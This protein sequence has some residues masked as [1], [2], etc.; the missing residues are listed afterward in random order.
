MAAR[1]PAAAANRLKSSLFSS[2]QGKALAKSKASLLFGNQLSCQ[3]TFRRAVSPVSSLQYPKVAYTLKEACKLVLQKGDI[4]TWYIDGRHDA[5][6][7][8]ANERMLGGGGV[9][10]AIHRAAGP[11]LLKACEDIPEVRPGVRCPTGSARI[12]RG[13]NLPVSKVIHTVGPIYESPK[14]SSALLASAYKSCIDIAKDH[15]IKYIAFPAISCGVY[16]YPLR[17]AS[18]VA[19]QTLGSQA[20]SIEEV[21]FVLFGEDAWKAWLSTA[22]RLSKKGACC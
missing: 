9:D 22:D 3:V 8:A 2:S 7:N 4:T 15:G 19:L 21:H 11:E 14:E 17:E 10:G 1:M 6:V 12:T 16:G 18:E 20:D 5:I 13:F